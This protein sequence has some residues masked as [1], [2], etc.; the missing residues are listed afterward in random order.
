MCSEMGT[1]KSGV[2]NVELGELKWGVG[3][4]G[5]EELG[6]LKWGVGRGGGGWEEIRSMRYGEVRSL[7]T[8]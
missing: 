2:V 1:P 3:R 6:E 4:G 7:S 5:G 8:L